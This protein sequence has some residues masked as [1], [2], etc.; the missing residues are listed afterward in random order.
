MATQLRLIAGGSPDSVPS[1]PSLATPVGGAAGERLVALKREVRALEMGGRERPSVAL[2]PSGRL[3]GL[4]LATGV[5]HGL[6]GERAVDCAAAL[7]FAAVAAGRLAAAKAGAA[8]V[9]WIAPR[10]DLCLAGAVGF[11]L[12]ADRLILVQASGTELLWAA[13]E[14]LRSPD[15]AVVVAEAATVPLTAARRLQLAAEAGGATGLLVAPEPAVGAHAIWRITAAPSSPAAAGSVGATRWRVD[16]VRGRGLAP[17]SWEMEWNDG[18]FDRSDRSLRRPTPGAGRGL[19]P[20][21]DRPAA[22][23]QPDAAVA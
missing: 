7:G 1:L 17:T 10:P 5:V 6:A 16:L 11:G 8:A 23:P 4:A 21:F 15:V 20:V 12:P 19:A 3:P 22:A 2:D 18:R 13:E 9:V 14:A